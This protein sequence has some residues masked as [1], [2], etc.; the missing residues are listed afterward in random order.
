MTLRSLWPRVFRGLRNKYAFNRLSGH[1]YNL[2]VLGNDC[3]DFSD[4]AKNDQKR[5]C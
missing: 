1:L 5:L 2:P 3:C 4:G